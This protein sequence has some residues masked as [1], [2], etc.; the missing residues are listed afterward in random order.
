MRLSALVDERLDPAGMAQ[1]TVPLGIIAFV[2]IASEP[3]LRIR[4]EGI[5]KEIKD[6]TASVYED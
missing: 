1:L 6:L 3:E 2:G 4:V 5:P